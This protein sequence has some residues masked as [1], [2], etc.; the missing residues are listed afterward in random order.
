[1]AVLAKPVAHF[2]PNMTFTNSCTS[3]KTWHHHI[4]CFL[5][6]HGLAT[7]FLVSG[8]DIENQRNGL[9]DVPFA[10][11]IIYICGVDGLEQQISHTSRILLFTS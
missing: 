4:L 7:T 1:M 8:V 5:F 11:H 10:L 9:H 2:S 6:M 3:R